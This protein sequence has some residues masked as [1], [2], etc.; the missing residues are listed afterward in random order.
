[1]Q[2]DVTAA[3]RAA[4]R[5]T[6]PGPGS[7]HLVSDRSGWWRDPAL[8]ARLGPALAALHPSARPSVVVAPETTGFLLGPLVAVALGTGFVEAYRERPV[9][10][11]V[12]WGTAPAGHR[13]TPVTL[14]VRRRHLG[15]GDRVLIVDDWAT[16]GAQV[17]ALHAA[18]APLGAEPVGAAVIAADC[19]PAVASELGL[20]ALIDARDL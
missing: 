4:F 16:S 6:D 17:R 2:P 9:P 13:G 15:P 10:E 8:L 11:P 12:S 18:L 19:P 5:W 3:L 1:M 20:R 14:G 7:S